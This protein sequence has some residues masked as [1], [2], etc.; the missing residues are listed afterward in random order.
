[1]LNLDEIRAKN[2]KAM[3]ALGNA[4]L[5]YDA[6]YRPLL[7]AISDMPALCDEV[8]ADRA[9]IK[10]LESR[11]Q[12]SDCLVVDHAEELHAA[13]KQNAVLT[14]AL[15]NAVKYFNCSR[16]GYAG[17]CS[18]KPHEN[19]ADVFERRAREEMEK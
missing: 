2:E 17:K 15:E 11:V 8:E 3:R 1:M 7:E 16:C 9:K 10:E 13:N 14:R 4:E 6:E 12:E 19:C 18:I 5:A